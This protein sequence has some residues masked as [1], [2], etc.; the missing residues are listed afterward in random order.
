MPAD[1]VEWV[2]KPEGGFEIANGEVHA[3]AE[4]ASAILVAK[5]QGA[6]SNEVRLSSVAATPLTLRA[7]A[8]PSTV[9]EGDT[10]V[11]RV[12]A[13]GPGGPVP[14]SE[15]GLQFESTAPEIVRIAPTTGAFRGMTPGTARIRVTHS[16]AKEPAEVSIEVTAVV[17][18]AAPKPA[19]LRLTST[20]GDPLQLAVASESTDW[21]AEAV[22]PDGKVTDVTGQ[23]TLQADGD[24]AN[25]IITIR[26][27]KIVGVSPGD[28]TLQASYGDVRTTEGLKVH[29]TQDAEI[30]EI[31]IVPGE[32]TL[33][34]ATAPCCR[35]R[36][37]R[38]ANASEASATAMI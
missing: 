8:D 35:P 29:V 4:N 25:P 28:A 1:R 23:V 6:T 27:R 36:V 18:E 5:Y 10:G 14:L 13:A 3:K 34:V 38:P 19:S 9:R 16:A 21:K 2:I 15:D 33:V 37:T 32:V 11:I 17:P 30:D 31:R 20:Q 26:D 22:F 12:E 24:P 7:T